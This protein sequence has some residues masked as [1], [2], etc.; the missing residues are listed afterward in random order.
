MGIFRG[1]FS[2]LELSTHQH[3]PVKQPSTPGKESPKGIRS[4][5]AGIHTAPEIVPDHSS[6]LFYPD[7]KTP[8]V[9]EHSIRYS[10]GSTSLA[11]KINSTQEK[12]AF[13]T[14]RSL[15]VVL[16]AVLKPPRSS[17]RPSALSHLFPWGIPQASADLP[18]WLKH[19]FPRNPQEK[20]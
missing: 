3:M 2:S 13:C 19:L 9:T 14:V 20:I 8:Q 1:F 15:A 4:V 16:E 11:G 17:S 7:W 6:Q 5:V 18:C 12:L 10:K